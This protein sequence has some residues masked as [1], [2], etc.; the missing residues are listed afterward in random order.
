MY[1]SLAAGAQRLWV[2]KENTPTSLICHHAHLC[3]FALMFQRCV[4]PLPRA[5]V[6]CPKLRRRLSLAFLVSSLQHAQQLTLRWQPGAWC[7]LQH[8]TWNVGKN[9]ATAPLMLLLLVVFDIFFL[10]C[11]AV[12]E[13]PFLSQPVWTILLANL[14][15]TS[16]TRGHSGAHRV[17]KASHLWKPSCGKTETHGKKGSRDTPC[18]GGCQNRAGGREG[19]AC[20]RETTCRT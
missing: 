6:N 7:Q 15:Q 2:Q 14:Q 11:C 10:Q 19:N 18:E 4:R 17:Q 20:L 5:A 1:S 9:R 16:A 13:P 3:A 12:R 8:H